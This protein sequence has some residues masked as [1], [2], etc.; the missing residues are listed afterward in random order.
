MRE[1]E[2]PFPLLLDSDNATY[3]GY[4][5]QRS[6]SRVLSPKMFW[7]YFVLLLRGRKLRPIQG[8]PYQL[9]GDFIVDPRGVVR[10]AYPSR[11]PSDRPSIQD[12]LL[13]ILSIKPLE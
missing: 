4:G 3:R 11:D 10:Y 2:S 12:L 9:G 7:H 1:T 8:D 13:Q 6:V 5:L